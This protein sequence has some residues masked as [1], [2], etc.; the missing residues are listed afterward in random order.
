MKAMDLVMNVRGIV[1]YNP[2]VDSGYR[3]MRGDLKA[4]VHSGFC[5]QLTRII[6]ED[7]YS[8]KSHAFY[9]WLTH[10]VE[11]AAGDDR[12]PWARDM[13]RS[14]RNAGMAKDFGDERYVRPER[15]LGDCEPGV[16]LFR[17]DTAPSRAG[18]FIG[19]VGVLM[20][21]GMVLEN[22][23]PRHRSG[24][25]FRGVTALTPLEEFRVTTVIQFDPKKG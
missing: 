23:H 10:P 5:L 17:W 13:E 2:V 20:P 6:I 22:V 24:S 4:P 1:E 12:E 8:M 11:R 25:F 9:N 15:I 19:H 3:I 18:T 14:L 7:A 21:G 16:L